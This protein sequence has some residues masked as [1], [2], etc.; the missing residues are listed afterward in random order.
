MT[1]IR[2]THIDRIKELKESLRSE[3]NA[4]QRAF[5]LASI[6]EECRKIEKI[7]S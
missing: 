1:D 4:C 3:P 5:L 2:Q 6:K 7:D